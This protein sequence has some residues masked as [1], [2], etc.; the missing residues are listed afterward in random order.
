[1]VNTFLRIFLMELPGVWTGKK[2]P[3]RA[4]LITVIS[5]MRR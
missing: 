3:A 4:G 1:M 2:N 5:L